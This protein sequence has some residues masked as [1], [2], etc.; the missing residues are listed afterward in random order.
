MLMNSLPV[1]YHFF[2]FF[3]ESFFLLM[4]STCIFEWLQLAFRSLQAT[5]SQIR[6]HV[7]RILQIPPNLSTSSSL[8]SSP[9]PLSSSS[10]NKTQP[11]PP[12]PP[13]PPPST[14]ASLSPASS[15]SAA[16]RPLPPPPPPK[17]ANIRRREEKNSAG[18]DV[19]QAIS[20][21][22]RQSVDSFDLTKN[23]EVISYISFSKRIFRITFF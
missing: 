15:A 9:S 22:L 7:R 4:V 2:F 1:D 19:E 20:S 16:R 23:T 6:D 3:N 13:L 17:N 5:S 10:I 12:P 8:S 18:I 11:P 14:T 21:Y